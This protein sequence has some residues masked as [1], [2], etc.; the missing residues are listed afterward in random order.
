[1]NFDEKSLIFHKMLTQQLRSLEEAN[2][3]HRKI[4]QQVPPM[5]EYSLTPLGKELI[6]ILDAMD[7]WGKRF[8]QQFEKK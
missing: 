6:P 5:V 4:Y 2:L 3:V 8:V 1:M 7:I